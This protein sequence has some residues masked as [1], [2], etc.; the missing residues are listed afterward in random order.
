MHKNP[1]VSVILVTYNSAKFVTETLESIKEQSYDNIE[2]IITDDCSFDGTVEVCNNWIEK[3][4]TRFVKTNIITVKSN[5]GIPANCNRGANE[6]TG[7]WL[8]FVAGDDALYSDA[9]KNAAAFINTNPEV[10][11]F[12]ST[13]DYFLDE[14]KPE[15]KSRSRN[16]EHLSF[17][18]MNA[19]QQYQ[20]LLSLNVIHA[21]GIFLQ[22][23][24][25]Q[26]CGMFVEQYSFL[27]DHPMW[28]KITKLGNKIFY[29]NSK[30][31]MY[32]LHSASVFSSVN[33][34]RFLFNNYYKRKRLFEKEM[35]LPNIG[36]KKRLYINYVY[37]QKY[38]F[39]S[40]GLNR[41]NRLCRFMFTFFSAI[42]PQALSEFFFKSNSA[43]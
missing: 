31:L 12:S 1:L 15:R 5:T 8:K 2:L 42:S 36:L 26:D 24:L 32:R 39:D 10:K 18:K 14:L 9:V 38:L 16:D 21:G 6:A 33:S 3:N 40:L 11:I 23:K 22:K 35:I 37:Y 19:S 43:N 20:Q 34:N 30:T 7:E 17:Y 29:L 13:V 41:N 4:K 25:L 28:L 27:E